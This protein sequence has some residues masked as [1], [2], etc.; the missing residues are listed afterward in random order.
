MRLAILSA[1]G[2]PDVHTVRLYLQHGRERRRRDRSELAVDGFLHLTVQEGWKA[3]GSL[4]WTDRSLDHIGYESGA[5][6]L[7]ALV[8][9]G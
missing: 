5:L 6:R 1:C 9:H 3:M 7:S 4:A 2:L 8:G